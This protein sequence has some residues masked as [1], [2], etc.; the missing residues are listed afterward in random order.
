M[1]IWLADTVLALHFALVVFVVGGLLAIVLARRWRWVDRPAFRIAHVL[2]IAIVVAE[3]WL[4]FTCP[5]TTLEWWLRQGDNAGHPAPGF[6]QTWLHRLLYFDAPAWV[7]VAGYT[8][9]GGL[10]ALAWWVYP[11]RWR[12][13]TR[14]DGG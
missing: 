11:P 12:Q 5:L 7:F 9:F 8:L 3:S 14:Q 4:D 10:V 2:A 6:V 1:R 13:N